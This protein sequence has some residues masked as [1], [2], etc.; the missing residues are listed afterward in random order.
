LTPTASFGSVANR[1]GIEGP[2]DKRV[3]PFLLHFSSHKIQPR[4]KPP[5]PFLF[6]NWNSWTWFLFYRNRC[7]LLLF[8]I[9]YPIDAR[10][11]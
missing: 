10:N 5:R 8:F 4:K 7:D 6:H 9:P 3:H 1:E 11:M 2:T